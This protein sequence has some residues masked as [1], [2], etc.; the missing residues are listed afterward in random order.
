MSE[1]QQQDQGLISRIRQDDQAAFRALFD[2]YYARLIGAALYIL[3]DESSAKD[4]VQEVYFQVWKN[5]E[6]LEITSSVF[7]YLK[8]STIN[9]SLNQIKSRKPFVEEEQLA[10]D[11]STAP[12]PE[13]LLEAGDVQTAVQKGLDNLPEK[14]RAIFLLRRIEGYSVKEIASK[15]AI[16]PK[17]VENQI[18]KALK[19]LKIY[20][21]HLRKKDSG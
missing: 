16:S 20:V 10:T 1:E 15:M 2:K 12:T 8:R 17:T 5:R 6:K 9:R 7:G 14:C 18:T 13:Q 3:K 21:S 19:V 4:A 11:A